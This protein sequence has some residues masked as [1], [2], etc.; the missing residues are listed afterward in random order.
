MARIVVFS[1]ELRDIIATTGPGSGIR[2][3]DPADR[4]ALIAAGAG[5]AMVDGT[6]GEGASARVAVAD[7]AGRIIGMNFYV[8]A[9]RIRAYSW[10]VVELA[11]GRDVFAMGGLVAPER[12]GRNL[13]ADIKGFAARDFA[14][15]GYGRMISL[16]EAGNVASMKAHARIGAVPL[17]TLT[18][19]RVG[20]LEL[21]W[22]SRSLQHV[23]WGHRPF[24]LGARAS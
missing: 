9:E 3:G 16:V 13:L 10:L 15:R 18:R 5:A 12:R 7:E 14:T 23:R 22:I 24:V 20:R 6:V 4:A 8:A 1:A 19:V 21:V 2:W 17:A 11:A